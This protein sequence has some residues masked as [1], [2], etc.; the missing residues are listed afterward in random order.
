MSC[1]IIPRG[2]GLPESLNSERKAGGTKKGDALQEVIVP[3]VPPVEDSE[4]LGNIEVEPQ[5][6]GECPETEEPAVRKDRQT[7]NKSTAKDS[8]ASEDQ[9][10]PT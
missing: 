10:V 7:E 2:L 5:P 1:G 8:F 6:W 9:D 4:R 3:R